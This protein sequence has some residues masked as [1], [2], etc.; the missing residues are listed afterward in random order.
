ML[1]GKTQWKRSIDPAKK[2]EKK[3]NHYN[4]D[5]KIKKSFKITEVIK[6]IQ[7]VL[8]DHNEGRHKAYK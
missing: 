2:T 7:Q 3:L 1:Y 4:K 5:V 8:I 6:T